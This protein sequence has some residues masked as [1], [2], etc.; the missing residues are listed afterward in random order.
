[1]TMRKGAPVT[2]ATTKEIVDTISRHLA[3]YTD[4]ELAAVRKKFNCVLRLD[5]AEAGGTSSYV[6]DLKSQCTAGPL[7]EQSPSPH[8]TAGLSDEDFVRLV[9]GA[10]NHK[11]LFMKGR[12]KVQGNMMLLDHIP[13]LADLLHTAE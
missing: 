11:R 8:V 4:D 1:M 3:R 2:D 10:E 5:I 12:L 13:H 6:L 7:T 9:N